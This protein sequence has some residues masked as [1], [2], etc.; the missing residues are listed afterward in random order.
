MSRL[1]AHWVQL[2]STLVPCTSHCG[3]SAAWMLWVWRTYT[4][5]QMVRA[6]EAEA[7]ARAAERKEVADRMYERVRRE[8][9]A[10][11]RAKEEE[12][13][14]INLLRQVG[15]WGTGGTRL[16]GVSTDMGRLT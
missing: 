6:R 3:S 10:A 9:E 16:A 12:D 7:V 15:G 8:M 11:M 14:L 1:G 2:G 5:P 4:R 13:Q